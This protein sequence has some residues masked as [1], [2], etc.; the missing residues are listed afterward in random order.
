MVIYDFNNIKQNVLSYG[1]HAG[2]KLGIDFNGERWFLK[3]PKSTK[4]FKGNIDISYS[5]SPLSEYIGSHIYELIGIPVHQTL[6]G[7]KDGKVVVACKD[8]RKNGNIQLLDFDSIIN[9][10]DS[11]LEEKLEN[12]SSSS[13][14]Y[15]IDLDEVIIVME[16]NPRFLELP[17][18]KN[19]FWDMFIV[20]ALIGNN[21]R[22]NGNWG[23]LVD[24]LTEKL[25]LA[26]V[27]DNGASFSNNSSDNK[28]IKILTNEESFKM[29]AYESRNCAFYKNEKRINPLDYITEMKNQDCN[30]ALLR[31]FPKIS[32]ESIFNMIQEIP[33]EYDGIQIV[34]KVRKEYYCKCVEYRFKRCFEPTY[35]LLEAK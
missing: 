22:N 12:L 26:P 27:Y 33:E 14:Q 28:I 30:K 23:I 32:I 21:D 4:N 10:Y 17:E 20:D 19:R 29:S 9:I 5:T 31:L 34:S 35:K 15:E 11:D 16:N 8:F 6:L 2:K 24:S 13:S 7:V 1:G 18:L 25:E 3:F